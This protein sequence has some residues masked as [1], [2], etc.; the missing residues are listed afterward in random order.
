MAGFETLLAL[1]LASTALAVAARRL[2][3]P[4]PVV[5]VLGGVGVATLVPRGRL[6]E[7]EPDLAF[8]IFVPPL[9]FSGAIGTSLRGLRANVRAILRLAVGLVIATALVVAVVAR[10]FVHALDWH[11]AFV[12]G[13]IV[14]RFGATFT[15][16]PQLR[17]QRD[18]RRWQPD[19][20]R[21]LSERFGWTRAEPPAISRIVS[22]RLVSHQLPSRSLRSVTA[23]RVPSDHA[24]GEGSVDRARF[25]QNRA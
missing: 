15:V 16:G 4:V 19:R 18:R 10:T 9:L 2:K 1:L 22:S 13:A 6:I 24:R 3:L 8:G 20:S 23:C 7:I 14:A 25:G 17:G 21:A 12:L 11:G 5:M